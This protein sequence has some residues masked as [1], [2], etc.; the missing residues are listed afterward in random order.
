MD[1]DIPP[2]WTIV[3][4]GSLAA[5]EVASSGGIRIALEP[6]AGFGDGRHPTT[7]LCMQAIAALEG[8]PEIVGHGRLA[9][10]AQHRPGDHQ[11]AHLG[12]EAQQQRLDQVVR[13]AERVQIHLAGLGALHQREDHLG[14]G[15]VP[16]LE[17]D[18]RRAV[19]LEEAD[20]SQ[21]MAAGYAFPGRMLWRGE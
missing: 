2:R 11:L 8:T 9:L 3:E 14:E 20:F 10:L 21:L 5:P 15:L 18:Q 16:R 13:P 6:G 19:E 12:Q 7:V 1:I 17:I 4:P